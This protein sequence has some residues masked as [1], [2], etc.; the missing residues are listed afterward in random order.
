MSAITKFSTPEEAM[1][2]A[3]AQ[4]AGGSFRLNQIV[5]CMAVTAATAMAP[6][7]AVGVDT[8][9]RVSISLRGFS[10]HHH[11]DAEKRWSEFAKLRPR[12]ALGRRLWALRQQIVASG[13]KLLSAEEVVNE[14]KQRRGEIEA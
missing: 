5:A 8:R 7:A 6:K 11:A 2:A 1:G 13:A 4:I 10:S 3:T 12:T 14:V 9:N